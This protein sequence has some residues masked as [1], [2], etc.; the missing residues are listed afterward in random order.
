MR[1]IVVVTARVKNEKNEVKDV[2]TV[3]ISEK[4]HENEEEMEQEL[5]DNMVPICSSDREWDVE[6]IYNWNV[7]I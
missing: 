3:T 7:V 4:P 1:N 6:E 5:K 2:K